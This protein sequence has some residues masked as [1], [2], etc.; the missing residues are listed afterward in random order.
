VTGGESLHNNH[1]AHPRAAKF[2]MSAREYDPS[3]TVIR[4]LAALRVIK[5]PEV[6]AEAS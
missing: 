4:M 5:V 1:H 6:A 3:W 2:S